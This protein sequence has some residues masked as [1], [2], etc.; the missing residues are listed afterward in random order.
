DHAQDARRQRR[1]DAGVGGEPFADVFRLADI[2]H[3]AGGIEHSGDGGGGGGQPH[4]VLD[5]RVADRQRAFGNR[6]GSFLA[7]VLSGF[8]Q[9]RPA[10]PP[11]GG[12]CGGEGWGRS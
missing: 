9:G 7:S 8:R 5:G 4:R 11:A 10:I 1:V 6:L 3:V 2:Q 12:G